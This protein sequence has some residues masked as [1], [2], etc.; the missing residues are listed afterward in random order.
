MGFLFQGKIVGNTKTT[1]RGGG[2]SVVCE[3]KQF[4]YLLNIIN[5]SSCDHQQHTTYG[6]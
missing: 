6:Q 5:L 2:E 1:E 4:L 3:L